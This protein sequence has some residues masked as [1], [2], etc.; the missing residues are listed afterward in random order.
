MK[1]LRYKFESRAWVLS[2][3]AGLFLESLYVQARNIYVGIDVFSNFSTGSNFSA[4]LS[5]NSSYI[6]INSLIPLNE[7]NAIQIKVNINS[8]L[9]IVSQFVYTDNISF[10]LL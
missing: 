1:E 6:C 9:K 7:K 3:F 10:V 8:G 5:T 4:V 2:Y